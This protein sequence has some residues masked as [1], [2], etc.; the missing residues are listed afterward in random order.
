VNRADEARPDHGGADVGDPAHGHSHSAD[1]H[2]TDCVALLHGSPR[3]LL[4]HPTLTCQVQKSL[5]ERTKR[6]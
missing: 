4:T 3:R 5:G 1:G 2:V 6:V